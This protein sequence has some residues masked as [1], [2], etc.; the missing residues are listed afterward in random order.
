MTKILFLLLILLLISPAIAQIT[1]S[2]SRQSIAFT[3]INIIDVRRGSL[4]R[5]MTIIIVGDSIQE[6]GKTGKVHILRKALIIDAHGKF[7]IPGLWDM[8]VHLGDEEFD[9][10]SYLRLFIANGITGV[11]IM[12]GDPAFHKW[13][14]E[15]E[16][17]T[18]LGPRMSIASQV[19]GAGDLS[20]LSIEKTLEEVRR[21]KQEGVD[22]IKVHDNVL[23]EAYF[24]LIE[25]AKRLNLPVEGHVPLSITAA[26]ASSSGQRSIEH[27]TGL[28]EA[29][30]D[31]RQA[32]MLFRI[33]KKNQTWHC[34][35]LIMRHNYALLN[36][37]SLAADSRLKYVKP[38]WK[39]R[40]LKMNQEAQN[41]SSAEIAA[42]RQTIRLEDN[43]LK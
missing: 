38:R 1:A 39:T 13:R 2:S 19:I 20:N 35:T 17:G 15:I 16:N 11:R 12:E 14:E 41:W 4:A 6:I 26:E 25:E 22:F 27:F 36:D 24:A 7:L 34:P 23:R 10:D 42:R 28:D 31:N 40:W 37:Q 21:A 8:H 29:K 43:L 33:L 3:H 30:S 18:L 5:N 9:K 32:Q